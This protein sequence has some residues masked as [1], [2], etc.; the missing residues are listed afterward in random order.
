MIGYYFYNQ[1]YGSSSEL[2]LVDQ[3]VFEKFD[4]LEGVNRMLDAGDI[5]VYDV[6]KYLTS[7]NSQSKTAKSMSRA[8]S[9]HSSTP[10]NNTGQFASDSKEVTKQV[11][12]RMPERLLIC[13]AQALQAH[14]SLST[15]WSMFLNSALRAE[16]QNGRMS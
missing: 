8:S 10:L 9:L 14:E 3:N 15:R 12:S 6:G 16:C 11:H 1:Q 7:N 2:K 5:V 13:N 4:G